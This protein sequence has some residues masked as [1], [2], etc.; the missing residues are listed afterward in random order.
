MKIKTKRNERKL[1]PRNPW[2]SKKILKFCLKMQ[3]SN[4]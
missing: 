4:I 3:T 2:Q 1:C